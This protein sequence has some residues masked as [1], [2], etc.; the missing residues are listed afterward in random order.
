MIKMG[1]AMIEHLFE[2]VHKNKTELKKLSESDKNTF[3]FML[4][5]INSMKAIDIKIFHLTMNYFTLGELI[6]ML[7]NNNDKKTSY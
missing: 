2:M 7:E 6:N 3:L 5:T 4:E 1:A